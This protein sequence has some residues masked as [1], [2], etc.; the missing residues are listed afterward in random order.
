MPDRSHTASGDDVFTRR[1]VTAVMVLIAVLAFVFSFG[2]VWALA[3]RLGIPAS[4]APLVAPMVD[5]SVVG[6][7]VGLRY[8][9]L[10]GVPESELT[11]ATR[12]MHL[13]GFLTLALNVADPL[14]LGLYGKAAVDAV[15]PVLLLGWGKVGPQFLRHFHT[16]RPV[17]FT[18]GHVA[19]VK[20]QA[21]D[22]PAPA[23]VLPDESP[24]EETPN[25]PAAPSTVTQDPK[26]VESRPTNGLEPPPALVQAARRLAQD[27]HA[28]TGD[29]I[30][31]ATL[32]QKLGLP[33]ALVLAVQARLGDVETVGRSTG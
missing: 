12:L 8:L 26:P 33:M 27:H 29:P 32:K 24:R 14:M 21:N 5:L 6:L 10:R 9:S 31:T 4:I 3:L 7:L 28:R 16:E 13:C 15:A 20:L 22:E 2:N 1:T 18:P 11:D 17:D 25:L 30:D 23:P 19:P